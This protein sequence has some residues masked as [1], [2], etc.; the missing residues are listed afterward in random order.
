MALS[1]V[2]EANHMPS[3]LSVLNWL[4]LALRVADKTDICYVCTFGLAQEFR[5]VENAEVLSSV[6]WYMSVVV[7]SMN[8]SSDEE[9][10]M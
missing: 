8:Q 6:K 2:H 3:S 1:G 10:F 7:C 9:F 4:L 5:L